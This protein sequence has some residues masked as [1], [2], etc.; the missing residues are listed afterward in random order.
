M[1]SSQRPSCCRS[2]AY[3]MQIISL[4][5]FSSSPDGEFYELHMPLMPINLSMIIHHPSFSPHP[6]PPR[7]PAPT[8]QIF[9]Q[10]NNAPSFFETLSKSI[11]FQILLALAYLH[12]LSIAHRDVKPGNV[13]LS[14]TGCIKLIDFGVSWK[15]GEVRGDKEVWQETT[16]DMCCQVASGPYRAPELLFGPLTYDA[17]ATDLWSLGAT[18]AS[19]YTPLRFTSDFDEDYSSSDSDSDEDEEKASKSALEP[20]IFPATGSGEGAEFGTWTRDTLFDAD[21]GEIGLAWSIFKILGTPNETTWPGFQDLPDAQKLRFTD[22]PAVP[23]SPLLPNLPSSE[24]P[25]PAASPLNLIQQLLAY[26]PSSRLTA[27]AA[28]SHPWFASGNLVLPT[29]HPG[30][31]YGTKTVEGLK[32]QGQHM[33]ERLRPCVEGEMTRFER[34]AESTVQS[35]DLW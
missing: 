34:E 13:L 23:L 1:I 18:L 30:P 12:D 14:P 2:S 8:S 21:R 25:P 20:F 4:L 10:I 33:E 9:S 29:G 31:T 27:Q 5:A 17:R 26:P 24:I 35:V 6:L 28:L 22:V 15:D 7:S 11:S 3:D 16:H 32:W 19:F